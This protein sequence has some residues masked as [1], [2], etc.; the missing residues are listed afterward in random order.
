MPN[1]NK[2]RLVV[3]EEISGQ[4]F[5]NR[6]TDRQTDGQT[7]GQT[8]RQTDRQADSSIP[9]LHYVAGGIISYR[10]AHF[11]SFQQPHAIKDGGIPSF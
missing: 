1:L 6:Q 5:A 2:I 3:T 9:P 11:M 8:D 10:H 4:D 7:D